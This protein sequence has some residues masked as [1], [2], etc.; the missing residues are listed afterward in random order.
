QFGLAVAAKIAHQA[1]CSDKSGVVMI[2]RLGLAIPLLAMAHPAHAD[3]IPAQTELLL[4]TA[5][6]KSDAVLGSTADVAKKAFPKSAKE[7]DALVKQLRATAQQRHQE[8]LRHLGLLRGWK[9]H[10]QIGASTTN[11]NTR[12]TGVAVGLDFSRDGLKWN[13]AFNAT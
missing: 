8:K 3:P 7:I 11:G 9:G 5:A 2:R 1:H 6:G 13:H 12:S 10:G 4:R